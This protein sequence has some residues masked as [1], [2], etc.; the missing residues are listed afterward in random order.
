VRRQLLESIRGGQIG[1]GCKYLVGLFWAIGRPQI[2]QPPTSPLHAALLLFKGKALAKLGLHTAAR[3]AL[4][5][6]FRRKKDRPDESLHEIQYQRA[7]VY[8]Q[9]GRKKRSLQELEKLYS[10]DPDF[11]DV[12]ERLGV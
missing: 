6:A 11:E 12:A 3:N 4:T 7:L 9:L 5:A 1:H 10:A 2:L 8:A